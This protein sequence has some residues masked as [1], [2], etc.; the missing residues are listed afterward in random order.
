MYH[1]FCAEV[2]TSIYVSIYRSVYN[3]PVEFYIENLSINRAF[4]YSVEFCIE[5]LS[6]NR[7][8][9]LIISQQWIF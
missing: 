2:I 8:K 4:Q 5:N 7:Y 3:D 6:I 1:E 9:E